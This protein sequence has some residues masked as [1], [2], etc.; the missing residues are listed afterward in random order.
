M[1]QLLPF[2]F[3][4]ILWKACKIAHLIKVRYLLDFLLLVAGCPGIPSVRRGNAAVPWIFDA[5]DGLH[6][7]MRFNTLIE[8]LQ[9]HVSP[10]PVHVII[11]SVFT[12]LQGSEWQRGATRKNKWPE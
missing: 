6:S 9:T 4:R 3:V 1:K 8:R 2:Q 12:F 5:A 7:D 10:S 11:A